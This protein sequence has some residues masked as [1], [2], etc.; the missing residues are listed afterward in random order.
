MIKD[1]I[2][3]HL[4]SYAEFDEKYYQRHYGSEWC[5]IHLSLILKQATPNTKR[6]VECINSHGNHIGIMI[7]TNTQLKDY[8]GKQLDRTNILSFVKYQRGPI[9]NMGYT[10]QGPQLNLYVLH[11]PEGNKVVMK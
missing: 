1:I 3:Y 8:I 10:S 5:K 11:F 4:D 7:A 2:C 9:Q 6:L